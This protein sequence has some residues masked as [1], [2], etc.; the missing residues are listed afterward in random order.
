MERVAGGPRKAIDMTKANNRL[1]N[2]LP[3]QPDF[4]EAELE[5]L[6]NW[7]DPLGS[8]SKLQE[9]PFAGR[10]LVSA[11]R[12]ERR[13]AHVEHLCR[14]P[15]DVFMTLTWRRSTPTAPRGAYLSQQVAQKQVVKLLTDTSRAMYG[16]RWDQNVG[17]IEPQG[18]FACIAWEHHQDGMLHAHLVVGRWGKWRYKNIHER[19]NKQAGFAWV[20]PLRSAADPEAVIAYTVKYCVKRNDIE[21]F[22]TWPGEHPVVD[23]SRN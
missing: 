12:E 11:D 22:G 15:L 9:R 7:H 2:R 4:T 18:L 10:A 6:R 16:P 17:R 23:P 20:A 8:L 19:W 3:Q 21:Y 14:Y 1:P 5:G 13:Q